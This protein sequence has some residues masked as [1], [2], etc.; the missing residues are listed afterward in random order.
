MTEAQVNEQLVRR[1]FDEVWNQKS[2]ATIDNLLAPGCIAYGLPGPDTV[3]RGPEAFKALHSSFCAAFP[4]LY[5]KV[6]DVI[7][8]GDRVAARWRATGTHLGGQLGFAPTGRK[9][10]LDGAT[11]F[12]VHQSKIREGWNLMDMGHF[13][14]SLRSETGIRQ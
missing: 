1:W 2:E 7:A 11:I 3:L 14:A 12:V 9:V 4:D 10:A 6:E 5:I 13:Y 8:A